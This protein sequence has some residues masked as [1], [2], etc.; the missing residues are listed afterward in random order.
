MRG[1][2]AVLEDAH[3]LHLL[4]CTPPVLLLAHAVFLTGCGKVDVQAGREPI[5]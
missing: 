2:Q 5:C 3:G 4:Y 1:H